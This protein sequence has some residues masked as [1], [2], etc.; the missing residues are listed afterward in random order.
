M[1]SDNE[2]ESLSTTDI[3]VS[4][5]ELT[6]EHNGTRDQGTSETQTEQ[7]DLNE[8]GA[9]NVKKKLTL[10]E[11]LA[12]AAKKKGKNP[13]NSKSNKSSNRSSPKVETRP[14]I[15]QSSRTFD[16]LQIFDEFFPKEADDQRDQFFEQLKQFLADKVEE[17][18]KSYNS[19]IAKLENELLQEKKNRTNLVKNSSKEDDLLQKLQEKEDQVR[20]LLDEGTKL[21]KKEL[22]LNQT[23]KKLK[24]H[25]SELEEDIENHEKSI[26][27]LTKKVES[28]E[29][30]IENNHQNER[31][32]VEEKLARETL[33]SKYDSLI[34]AND[35]LTD[36]LKEIKFSKLDVQLE[37]AQKQLEEEKIQ[38]ENIK[39]KYEKLEISFNQLKD[40]NHI[41]VEDLKNKL[42]NEENVNK[43][44]TI[45][46]KRLEEKI[47]TLRFQNESSIPTENNSTNSEMIQLQYEEAQENWKLIESSYLTK[48]NDLETK[49]D[50]LQNMNV[51]YSK[52]IKILNKDLKQNSNTVSEL[53][54]HG[55]SLLSEIEALKKKN[56]S[57]TSTNSMLE[58][59]LQQLKIEFS[60]EKESF[61]KKV[62]LLEEDKNNL[63]LKLK[64]RKDDFASTTQ[65]SQNTFYLQDLSSSSS[66]NYLKSATTSTMGRSASNPHYNGNS[67]NNSKRFS[68]QLGESSTTPRVSSSNSTYSFQKL[69]NMAPMTPQD[70]IIR[71]QS[72]MISIDSNEGKA[73]G[74][75]VNNYNNN[76]N[77]LSNLSDTINGLPN[78]YDLTLESPNVT[79]SQKD[80]LDFNDEI[81]LGMSAENERLSTI[82]EGATPILGN[83]G[84]PGLNI[85]LIKKLGTHVRMLE[86]EVATLKDETWTLEKDKESATNEIVRLL[87]DN[88]KVDEIRLEVK[89]KE[90]E[91]LKIN[92]NYERV[93]ILLGEKEERVNE[94]NADVDDLKD[95]LRQQVQQMVEMQEKINQLGK[96]QV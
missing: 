78:E 59:N 93:L 89:D 76:D 90:D 66:L 8:S 44:K 80:F 82:N 70:K 69:N 96:E 47:E 42:K 14:E 71:H 64:L 52:K 11:R 28:L 35:S 30:Q 40:E 73:L 43:E 31:V 85:Q 13:E 18:E 50:E 81:P 16:N 91:I 6:K 37:I 68:I 56:N 77:S 32:L 65:I 54:E 45:E 61:K 51:I 38:Y 63:E 57:L 58:D 9:E 17:V 29:K 1:E 36:E 4:K 87:D 20:E 10:Q 67:N 7:K 23:I 34:K 26:E 75:N 46:L 62:Q 88:R 5:S 60:N 12:L 41:L 72:S 27:E 21:S 25:E 19:K 84:S 49:I 15:L 95:L 2:K 53:Q 86:L 92:K 22:T 39:E 74:L 48:L 3:D 79:S 94:L 33:Q 24:T 83:D 55:N